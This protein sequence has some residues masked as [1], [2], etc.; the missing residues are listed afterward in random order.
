MKQLSRFSR[1]ATQLLVGGAFLAIFLAGPSSQAQA[2]PTSTDMQDQA[3]DPSIQSK[4]KAEKLK[5]NMLAQEENKKPHLPCDDPP[6]TCNSMGLST[7][8]PTGCTSGTKCSIEG[9]IC[10][11]GKKCKTV[12]APGQCYCGCM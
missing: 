10:N 11:P 2:A 8:D 1:L 4:L 3:L 5:A 12:G 7:P 6:G 9:K